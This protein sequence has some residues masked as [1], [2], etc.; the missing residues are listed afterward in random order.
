MWCF[1]R[2]GIICFDLILTNCPRSFQNSWVLETGLSDFQKVTIY[3]NFQDFFNDTFKEYLLSKL[4]MEN[5]RKSKHLCKCSW[6]IC[7]KKEKAFTRKQ[8]GF[9]E[10]NFEKDSN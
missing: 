8:Y 9:D 10:S 2:F 6:Q 5:I 7:F 4:A 1:A 3:R